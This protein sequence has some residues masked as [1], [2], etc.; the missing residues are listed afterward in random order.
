MIRFRE[1]D[2][3]SVSFVIALFWGLNCIALH[4]F[5]SH[6]PLGDVRQTGRDRVE[7]PDVFFLYDQSG[8]HD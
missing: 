5:Q 8:V 3:R 6:A 7:M 2:K 1:G 4:P